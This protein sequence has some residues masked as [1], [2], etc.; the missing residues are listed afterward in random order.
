MNEIWKDV[1]GY[2]GIYLV[3]NLGRVM[4]VK[5]NK[6]LRLIKTRSGYLRCGLCK[7]S[8]QKLYAVHRLVATAFLPNPEN[9]S[10][11]NHING[12][13]EDNRMENL[14]WATPS[15][16]I[17]H[18]YKNGLITPPQLG[19]RGR[20]GFAS[21][22]VAQ[23]TK[24]GA[25]VRVWDCISEAAKHLRINGNKIASVRRGNT[26]NKTAGGFIWKKIENN[27]IWQ[28]AV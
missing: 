8:V 1:A 13:K 18:G 26:P 16:N 15:E 27:Q 23:Y 12:N 28:R 6:S 2:E 25:L 17:L 22:S 21:K 7:D 20:L 14:E 9:K 5:N 4:R 19:K 3:S 11:V 10:Q 24:D